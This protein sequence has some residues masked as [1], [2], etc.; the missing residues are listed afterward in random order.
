MTEKN[1]TC[2]CG[3]HMVL[4]VLRSAAGYYIGFSCPNCGPHSRE[5]S[6]FR[7]RVAATQALAIRRVHGQ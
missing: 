7:S 3:A 4:E 5:S 1:K 6:Y 2:A